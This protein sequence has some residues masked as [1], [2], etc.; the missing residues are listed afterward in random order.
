MKKFN[1]TTGMTHTGVFHA[2]DVFSTALLRILSPEISVTRE[3]KIPD[4]VPEDT[5]VFDIGFGHYDHHQKEAEI[6]D[7]G[8]KYAAFGLLWRD[9]G[10]LLVSKE[11]VVAFDEIFVQTLDNPDNGGH[12]NAMYQAIASFIPNWDDEEQNMDKAFNKAVDFAIGVLNREFGRMQ[13]SER[14][15]TEVQTALDNSDGSIVILDRFVPWQDVLIPSSAKFVIFPSL[16]GGFSAQAIPSVPGGRDQKVPFPA[17]W[18]GAKPEVLQEFVSGMTFC[19]VGRFMVTCDTVEQAVMAC[20]KTMERN[21][22]Q[23]RLG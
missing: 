18:A 19:H 11:N 9:Y 17:E 10:E 4:N 21:S 13:S 14:A 7:N 2:D 23:Y 6:R 5:I 20:K 12:I 3:F 1:Y 8:I 22:K 15:E 16:R